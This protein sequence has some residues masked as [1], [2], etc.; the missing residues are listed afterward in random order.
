MLAAVIAGEERVDGEAAWQVET[1]RGNSL[2]GDATGVRLRMFR[3]SSISTPSSV[4]TAPCSCSCSRRSFWGLSF[5][6]IKAMALVQ[7]QLLPERAPGSQRD[8]SRGAAFRS[9]ALVL[10]AW[11]T[12]GFCGVITRGEVKQGIVDRACFPPRDVAAKRRPAIHGGEHVGVSHAVLCDPDSGVPRAA[13]TRRPRP[14]SSGCVAGWCSRAWRSSG[15]STGARLHLGRGEWE[16][17]LRLAVFHGADPVAGEKGSSRRTARSKLTLVMFATAGGGLWR[18]GRG[19]R[20]GRRVRCS[21]RG[22][23]RRGCGLTARADGGLHAR[24]LWTDEHLAAEN[25]RDRGAA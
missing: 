12:G 23:R 1:A 18:A 4:P 9:G 8:L 2:G 20:A 21:C 10:L 13:L 16:T 15:I 22:L 19:L 11:Q 14:C 24:R 17:L 3:R 7:L 6:V 5:P 25:H